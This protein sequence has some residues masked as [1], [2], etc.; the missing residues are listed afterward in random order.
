MIR[1][2]TDE[3]FEAE[4]LEAGMP[5]VIGFT[6]GWCTMCDE[7]VPKM[8][9]AAEALGDEVRFC[10]ANIDEQR[11]LRI[12]FAVGALPSV[13][14]VRD[15]QQTLLFDEVFAEERLEERVRYMLEGGEA[16]NT[17]PIRLRR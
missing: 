5:C 4:V 14:F 9:D 6:A 8:E 12:M 10:I 2:I 15:G 7:M 17:R 11:G 13:V 16:P 3:S 1:E